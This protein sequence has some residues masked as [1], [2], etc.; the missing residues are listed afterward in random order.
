M[1][2]VRAISEALNC[3]VEWIGQNRT[4]VITPFEICNT[5]RKCYFV[6]NGVVSD[7]TEYDEQDRMVKEVIFEDTGDLFQIKRYFY[8][9]DEI[10]VEIYD[11]SDY[12]EIDK[13]YQ[14]FDEGYSFI[15]SGDLDW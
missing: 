8:S 13:Y 15:E 14:I 11:Y 9:E 10:R 12:P 6:E 3:D 4:V 1:V 7:V 2:P 5:I